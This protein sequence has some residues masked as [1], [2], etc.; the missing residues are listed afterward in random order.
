MKSAFAA[1]GLAKIEHKDYVP[2]LT[3]TKIP[4][5]KQGQNRINHS[6]YTDV[7]DTEFGNQ[8]IEGLELLEMSTTVKGGYYHCHSRV[9]FRSRHQ[10][11]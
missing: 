1:N 11:R 6:T 4:H 5:K 8:T 10:K 2:H 3:I 7:M 9:L